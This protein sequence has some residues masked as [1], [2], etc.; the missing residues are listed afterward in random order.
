MTKISRN[1]EQIPILTAAAVFFLLGILI[2]GIINIPF[3]VLLAS[4]LVLLA[5]AFSKIKQNLVFTFIFLLLCLGL[6]GLHLKNHLLL[7]VNHIGLLKL[8]G[9]KNIQLGGII[10]SD[11]VYAERKISFTLGVRKILLNHKPE[12]N[13]G[14]PNSRSHK[15]IAARGKVLVNIF[16]TGKSTPPFITKKDPSAKERAGFTY[17]DELIVEGRLYRP[18]IFG[19]GSNFSYRDY[20][21]NQGIYSILSV[22]KE[23]KIVLAAQGKGDFLKS[24]SLRMKHRFKDIFKQYLSPINSDVLSAIILGERQNFPERLRQAFVQTGTAHIIAISGFNVGIVAF[25]ILIFLKTM[26]IKRKVR[27]MIMLPIL[28]MHMLAVG[29][30]SSVV[31]ATLMALIVL[32]AYLID[33]EPHIINSLSLAALFILGYNPLQIFDIGFQLSFVSVLGIVILSPRIINLFRIKQKINIL[34]RAIL[35]SFS[36]S[37]SAWLATFGFVAYYFRIISP[38]TVLANLIIVP[39][40]SL[41]II[42]GFTLSLSAMACPLLSPSISATT[43]FILVFLFKVTYSLSHLP[44]AYFYL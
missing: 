44:F 23:N 24:L 9:I 10:D 19:A 39:L 29:A 21:R 4:C 18:F 43:N 5:T 37:L 11:P 42:L 12:G 33:R 41:A 28:V 16:N 35:N 15:S 32:I 17:G 3:F 14:Q 2:E 22:K 34:P 40:A 7:P 6:G 26:R 1:L 36:V 13:A 30:S 38:V 31:R 27:Y 8:Q 25:L 20:L